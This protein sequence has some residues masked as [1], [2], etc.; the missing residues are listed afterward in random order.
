VRDGQGNLVGRGGDL[1]EVF[2]DGATQ[3]VTDNGDGTY[4]MPTVVTL[5]FTPT[6]VIT[7]NGVPISG[8]PFHP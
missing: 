4:T 1:V 8:S 3:N 7:L 2:V 6:V 5:N